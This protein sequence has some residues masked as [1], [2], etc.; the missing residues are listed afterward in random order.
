MRAFV[1][2]VTFVAAAACVAPPSEREG[3]SEEIATDDAALFGSGLVEVTGF[4]R[5]PG[6]LRMFE[7][8]PANLPPN[9]AVV[10]VLHGCTTNALHIAGT[11]WNQLA[12]QRG[13][14]VVYPQQSYWNNGAYCFNWANP[15]G[16][17]DDDAK[18]GGGESESIREMTAHALRRHRGDAERVYVAGFSAGAAMAVDL[19][20]A[21]PDVYAA[22]ASFAG[23]PYGCASTLPE[24]VSCMMPGIE[25]S[26]SEHARRVKAAFPS[27][28]GRRPRISIWHGALDNVVFPKNQRELTKQWTELHGVG[29][30][31][32]IVDEVDG[33]PHAVWLDD[34]DQ[35]VVE[36]YRVEGMWHGFPVDPASGCGLVG[37]Y[38]FAHGICGA[39]RAF[40]F[41]E[42]GASR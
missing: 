25:R 31:P 21:Y 24:S 18:R 5:N 28:T 9:P 42:R 30:E 8:V 39:R 26:P 17:G 34:D 11:G 2:A 36:T 12:D 4:G 33:H 41:F 1:V 20:A 23:V 22:A 27:Y 14:I 19:A 16:F 6:A 40:E 37:P 3:E 15:M 7:H 32:S 29:A 13:F 10:V 38:A 35:K